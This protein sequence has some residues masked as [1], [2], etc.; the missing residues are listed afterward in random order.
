VFV[1]QPRLKIFLIIQKDHIRQPHTIGIGLFAECLKH[2]TKPEKH[3]AKSL[4]SVALDKESSA[5][6]TSVM[7]YL[8]STFYRTL[9]KDF[10][11][12][13]RVFGKRK[14]TVTVTGNRDDAFGECSRWHSAK[15]K[16][17]AECP[18]A[19]HSTASPP[20]VPL[21][22][23]THSVS[24]L[25]RNIINFFITASTYDIMTCGQVSW[26]SDFVCV[27]YNF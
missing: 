26:F 24:Q 15:R 19:H 27:L 20:V 8:P 11:E 25:S 9:D 7:T 5:N 14:V 3:S 1:L 4:S 21:S 18:P 10:T 12:C 22:V 13:H 16:L 2:S 17:F 23:S 6:C